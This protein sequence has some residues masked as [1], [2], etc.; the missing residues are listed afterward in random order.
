MYLLNKL[1]SG[2]C[3]LSC[4]APFAAHAADTYPVRSVRVLIP[5]PP[6][7]AGDILGRMLSARL[8]ETFGQQFVNDNRP[9]GGNVIA[10]E[11]AARAQAELERIRAILSPAQMVIFLFF[12]VKHGS[13]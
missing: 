3:A 9:G 12:W 5:F 6:A 11:L 7:G 8:T 10:T 4:A 1:L 2:L 13:V